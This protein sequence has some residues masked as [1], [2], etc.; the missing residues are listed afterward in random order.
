M[1]IIKRDDG[2]QFVLSAYRELLQPTQ[3]K[4][5]RNEIRTLA[6][7]HGEYIALFKLANGQ[8]EGVF[9]KD[10]GFLFAEAVWHYFGKPNDLI[11]CE[12]LAERDV[13]LVVVVRNGSVYL[14]TKIPYNT[15]AEEF[16][17]LIGSNQYDIYIY[18]DVPIS[19]KAKRGKFNFEKE[20][21]KSFTFLEQSLFNTIVIRDDL[22]LKPLEF[23]LHTQKIGKS[24][25]LLPAILTTALF[26]IAIAWFY[27]HVTKPK[28][29]KPVLATPQYAVNPYLAY[30][31]SYISPDPEIQL[32]ELATSIAMLYGMPGWQVTGV[33]FNGSNYTI[34]TNPLGGTISYLNQWTKD[35]N[36]NLIINPQGVTLTM[37]SQLP[38]RA[39]PTV[40]YPLQ[41][42]LFVVMDNVNSIMPERSVSINTIAKYPMYKS[43][44]ITIS[45]NDA[46]PDILILIGRE[47]HDLPVK[48]LNTHI[49]IN[50]GM[51]SGTIQLLALGN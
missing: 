36:M 9:S 11:Y 6:V 1:P 19:E 16:A 49:S 10:P 17:A 14:D 46:S 12:A 15:L 8:M 28:L 2:I 7:N 27:A 20:Q 42:V 45:V 21:I 43:A 25:I 35:R 40:I 34:Q 31:M 38:N 33:T 13:A 39:A 32:N 5:S 47:L 29:P 37:S 3:P 26:V 4:I 50:N 44:T 48:L 23:V 51:L 30:Q 22:Q 24:S 18:G 41:E